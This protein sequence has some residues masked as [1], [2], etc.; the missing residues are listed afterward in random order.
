MFKLRVT[1][2]KLR[3]T[4]FKLLPCLYAQTKGCQPA[5]RR[6]HHLLRPRS[7]RKYTV[8]RISAFHSLTGQVRSVVRSRGQ[9]Q[10]TLTVRLWNAEILRTVYLTTLRT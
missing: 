7:T 5:G 1:M 3:L 10:A 4:N 2:F 8:R 6:S 9:Q